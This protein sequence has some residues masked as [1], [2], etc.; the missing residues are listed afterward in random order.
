MFMKKA[1]YIE[2]IKITMDWFY[3]RN[4]IAPK[5]SYFILKVLS[6]IQS[7]MVKRI[8]LYGFSKDL[9]DIIAA[10]NFVLH[11]NFKNILVVNI[12]DPNDNL[13]IMEYFLNASKCY[14]KKLNK[15]FTL[16]A[17][18]PLSTDLYVEFINRFGNIEIPQASKSFSLEY[19]NEG[20]AKILD[21]LNIEQSITELHFY[22]YYH[23]YDYMTY[24][25]AF[26]VYKYLKK[27]KL[28]L[29]AICELW[30]DINPIELEVPI[31]NFKYL[32]MVKTILIEGIFREDSSAER[33]EYTFIC[34]LPRTIETLTLNACH[35]LTNIYKKSE[36]HTEYRRQ[37]KL[38]DTIGKVYPLASSDSNNIT[39]EMA[40]VASRI[41]DSSELYSGEDAHM[42]SNSLLPMNSLTSITDSS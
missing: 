5:N 22:S 29:N 27:L 32:T 3:K 6:G 20:D 42:L 18:Y 21:A 12:F 1:K 16:K 7:D 35:S 13:D 15:L 2:H 37:D 8:S 14:S 25:P 40:R 33:H 39:I 4:E 24:V 9:L 10:L 23:F 41:D 11:K 28:N 34:S 17:Y 19:Q 38:K 26:K 30:K 36:Q 31:A